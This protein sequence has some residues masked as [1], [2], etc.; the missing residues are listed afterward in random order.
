MKATL[1]S[2]ARE[3]LDV[4]PGFSFLLLLLFC[5]EKF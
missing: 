3:I 2:R 4:C 1:S 5:Q